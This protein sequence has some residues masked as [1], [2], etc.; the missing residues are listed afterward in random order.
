MTDSIPVA[1]RLAPAFNLQSWIEEHRHLLKPPVGNKCVY[2]GDFIVMVVGG[3]NARKDYHVDPGEEFFYQ[4]EGAM[5]LRTVQDGRAVE[6]PI[7]AGEVLLLPP[8][9]P[10]SPQR[11]A[12]TV[13][14]VIERVRRA[15]ELDGF[16]WYCERC[17]QLLYEEFFEL[18]DIEKQF[19]P[20]FERF[21]ADSAKRTCERCHAVMERS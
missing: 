9:V 16:Q 7:R 15:G 17:G 3:P 5:V 4:L 10:H 20:V 13:G 19:P 14:L 6:V 2:A 11:P 8:K 12:N 18:T 21:F 1:R